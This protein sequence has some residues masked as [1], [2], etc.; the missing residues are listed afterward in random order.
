MKYITAI[1]ALMLLMLAADASAQWAKSPD[2]SIPRT[3]DGEPN[4]TAPAPKAP[5]GKPDLSGIWL[6]EPD[7]KGTA[8]GIENIVFPRYFPN[9]AADMKPE[10]VPFLPE[11]RA[12]FEQRLKNQGKDA[13]GA[14]C[15][16]TGVPLLNAIPIPYKIIQTPRVVL[17]LYEE[18][19]VF[20]QIF[21]DGRKPVE[22]PEP[23]FMGYSTGRWEGDTLVV[24]TTGFN[25]RTWLDGMGHPHSDALHVVERFRRRSTGRLDVE[26]TI[27]DPK[28]YSKPITYTQSALLQADED[29]LEYFCSDNEKDVPHYK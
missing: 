20:R 10:E 25:D 29:L 28:M 14:H 2:K 7:P 18:N 15:K 3:R 13:P 16:P 11:A 9:I 21:L 6:P 5:D 1:V 26:M 17:I 4:L 19:S 24:D 8:R 27:N 22:D 23:R 12:I